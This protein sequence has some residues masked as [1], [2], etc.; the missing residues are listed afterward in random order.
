[1]A[2]FTYSPAVQVLIKSTSQGIIYDVSEDMVRGQAILR[3][4]APHQISFTL[5]NKNRRYDTLFAPNDLFTLYLKRTRKLL[6]MSGYLDSVPWYSTWE[7]SVQVFGTCTM[8]RL[9]QKRWD[10]GTVAALNLLSNTGNSTDQ[11][12]ADGGMAAKAQALITQVGGWPADTVRISSIPMQWAQ[13]IQSLYSAASPLLLGALWH[14]TG[15][16]A[17]FGAKNSPVTGSTNV[18]QSPPS[19]MTSSQRAYLNLPGGGAGITAVPYNG[20]FNIARPSTPYYCQMNWGYLYPGAGSL[21][22]TIKNWLAGQPPPGS[23]PVMVYNPTTNKTVLCEVAGDGPGRLNLGDI[24]VGLSPKALEVLGITSKSTSLQASVFVYWCDSTISGNDYVPGP[25][26]SVTTTVNE[27]SA[28]GHLPVTVTQ[29]V[30]V[31]ANPLDL[32]AGNS[33]DQG[34]KVAAFCEAAV[35][36]NYVWGG[37]GVVVSGAKGVKPGYDCSGL[38]VAAWASVGVDMAAAG[39]RSTE[40]QYASKLIHKF[41]DSSQLLPGDLVYYNDTASKQPSPNHEGVFVYYDSSNIAW[42]VQATSSKTGVMLVPLNSGLPIVAYGRPTGV[43]GYQKSAAPTVAGSA[44]IGFTFGSGLTPTNQGFVNYWDWFGQPPST[45]SQVLTGIRGLMNDQPL[46][47]FVNT[48]LNSSMRSWCSAPNGDFIAWFP[49]Y[50]GNYGYAGIVNIED[51]ELMDFSMAWSDNNM[52]TH[53]YVASSWVSQI[54]GSTPAGGVG[55]A[56]LADAEGVVSLEMGSISNNILQ[57]VLGL[58]PGDSSGF[59]NPQAILNRFGARP[60]FQQIGAIMGPMAQFWYALF[61]FQLN[62]ASMFTANV[63][64]TFMPELYPGML[65][66]L[67]DGFQAYVQQV[68]HSWDLTDG[69]PGFRTQAAIMAPSDWR[70]GG[71]YGL[72]AGGRRAV[73]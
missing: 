35:G 52:V 65:M 27:R 26:P 1:M 11:L 34:A 32:P 17:T 45:E 37:N 68:V 66:R 24:K 28:A 56:N 53:Q 60:N 46:L 47:P 57:V 41:T 51:V 10:P 5:M 39:L 9:L 4:N 67:R 38:A 6:V 7:R 50:F 62:W 14:S 12:R 30:P 21:R 22:S 55:L 70:G 72:P 63:P 31:A 19:T 25:W 71:L 2:I 40:A 20:P 33:S 48:V 59:G 42:T 54:F 15:G 58:K 23:G 13:N 18:P 44:S 36:D 8:K 69:G 3:T 29:A 64:M 61:L 16:A 43:T 73:V 49:D